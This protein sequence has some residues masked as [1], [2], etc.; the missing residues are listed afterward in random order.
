MISLIGDMN[1]CVFSLDDMLNNHVIES[2]LTE[3]DSKANP[4]DIMVWL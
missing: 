3:K 1:T 2:K 4:N